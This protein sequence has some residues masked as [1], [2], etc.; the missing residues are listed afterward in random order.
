TS[1]PLTVGQIG[2]WAKKTL[3]IPCMFAV[4]DLWPEAPIQ[5]GMVKNP[6]LKKML[7]RLE[8]SIYE[9]ALRIVVLSPGIKNYIVAKVPD[10][11]VEL[12]PS[13][14]VTRFYSP[15]TKDIRTSL[16]VG[17]TDVH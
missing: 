7:Y 3:A 13:L 2:L 9:Q 6:L 14:A 15:S 1:T 10:A 4:R 11:Q 17:L 12:I 8:K 5:I 16:S